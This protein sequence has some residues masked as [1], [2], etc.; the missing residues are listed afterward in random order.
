LWLAPG[1]SSR[2][3]ERLGASDA[4]ALAWTI[5]CLPQ[6]SAPLDVEP[7]VGAV[8]ENAC[9]DERGRGR[10]LPAVIAKLVDVLARNARR[11]GQRGLKSMPSAA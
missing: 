6:I 2:R 1:R 8:A 4:L 10:D 5:H 9:E 11:L 7:E 3:D